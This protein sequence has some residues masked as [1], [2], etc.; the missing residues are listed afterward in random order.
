[1]N[2]DLKSFLDHLRFEKRSSP[3]TVTSYETDIRQFGRYLSIAYSSEDI[4]KADHGM[5]RSWIVSLM[6]EGVGTRSVNR[7]ITTLKTF[8]RFLLKEKKVDRSPMV[9]ILA[10]KTSKRLP[11]FVEQP[12]MD[13][14]LDSIVFGEDFIAAQDK[15]IISLFYS[16]GMRLA[17]LINIRPADI[18]LRKRT[19][20][21]LGKRNKERVI[22]FGQ[23]LGNQLGAFLSLRSKEGYASAEFF[24]TRNN[25]K[26][27]RKF[28]YRMV[29]SYLGQVT[30]LNKKSPHV[31]RHTFATHMLNNGAELNAI[32]ELL[33]HSNLSATQ[34]YTHNTIEKLK[35]TYAK[36]HPKA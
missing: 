18:D 32:K 26:L 19:I 25:K 10:P 12:A 20:R 31:L 36:A 23:S 7:K 22:P 2:S 9:K 6:E 24:F 17:E 15:V 5:I 33:G 27:D 34:I 1:M 29:R 13:Q 11:A 4:A 16:T 3:H 21:V 28:V 30:T 14:L 8:Y 35:K